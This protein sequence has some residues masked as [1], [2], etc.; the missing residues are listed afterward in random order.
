MVDFFRRDEI[1]AG[2]HRFFLLIPFDVRRLLI[3]FML[4]FPVA[5]ISAQ[6]FQTEEELISKLE[7][8]GAPPEKLLASRTVVIYTP[9][10]TAKEIQS[11]QQSFA[12]TGIDAI[13]WFDMDLLLAGTDAA[14]ALALYLVRRNV[15]H[16]AFFRKDEGGYRLLFTVFNAKPSFIDEGQSAWRVQHTDLDQLLKEVYRTA[17]NSL[18]RQ[19]FLINGHP[20]T[21]LMINPIAGRRSEFFAIDL[22]VD[23]LAVPKFGDE[24]LDARLAELFSTYPF[25]YQLTEPGLSERELRSKG[26]LYVLR[27]IHARASIARELLGYDNSTG[28]S[29][30]TS[31]TFDGT[32]QV[33][34]NL[35]AEE[36]VF[37]FYFKHIESGNVFLGT[38]WDADTT[39][40][41]ALWN[42]LMAFKAELNL[43]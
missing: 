19:N 42:H 23:P 20:E 43:N 28:A 12:E 33:P 39:W 8:N 13:G 18:V 3:I 31:V 29:E 36:Q 38:K 2:R 37:K 4:A 21:N 32:E 41:Q 35:P 7:P 26:F 24:I 34:K 11:V 40:D 1:A 22:K 10:F 25:K 17:A 16:L 27:F 15:A 5:E 9:G 6:V 30:Y 14:R